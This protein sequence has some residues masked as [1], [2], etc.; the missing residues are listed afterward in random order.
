MTDF[1][2][3]TSTLSLQGSVEPRIAWVANL[4]HLQRLVPVGTSATSLM[5]IGVTLPDGVEGTPPK[6]NTPKFTELFVLA[7]ARPRCST[8]T[9]FSRQVTNWRGPGSVEPSIPWDTN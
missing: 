5:S 7:S 2:V 6:Q 4:L 3:T 1:S 8:F 9:S